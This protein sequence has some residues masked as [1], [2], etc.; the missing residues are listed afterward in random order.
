M[1]GMN[2]S[3]SYILMWLVLAALLGHVI[4]KGGGSGG[5]GA[6]GGTGGFSSGGKKA[7]YSKT[8]TS[9]YSNNKPYSRWD[10]KNGRKTTGESSLVST[11]LGKT[12]STVPRMYKGTRFTQRPI[13][14]VAAAAGVG[15]AGYTAYRFYKN[16][17]V[18]CS[19]KGKSFEFGVG[20]RKCS[21]WMCPIGQ[22][23][24]ACS[25]YSDSYCLPCTNTPFK[26][27]SKESFCE[28]EAASECAGES[29]NTPEVTEG[30]YKQLVAW[31]DWLKA[32]RQKDVP[33]ARTACNGVWSSTECSSK[34]CCYWSPNDVG[35]KCRSRAGDD[36]VCRRLED[37]DVLPR[38]CAGS[39]TNLRNVSH[40]A[41]CKKALKIPCSGVVASGGYVYTSPGNNNDCE[42]KKCSE[43]PAL[44][45][46]ST[47][48]TLAK[49]L[50][51]AEMPVSKAAFTAEISG[52][53]K[54]AIQKVVGPGKEVEVGEVEEL[55]EDTFVF[56][57]RT[58]LP[59]SSWLISGESSS[60]GD[61]AIRGEASAGLDQFSGDQGQRRQQGVTTQ[62]ECAKR[63]CEG[64][65]PVVAIETMVSTPIADIDDTWDMLN[66]KA[67]NTALYN[68]AIPPAVIKFA[69]VENSGSAD[70][71][72][73]DLVTILQTYVL[74]AVLVPL[75][76]L[77]YC[78]FKKKQA[79]GLQQNANSNKAWNEMHPEERNFWVDLGWDEARWSGDCAE[80]TS[81]AKDW[82]ELSEVE[83]AAAT[84]LG[85]NQ[86]IWDTDGSPP[87][88][89][90]SPA[91][92]QVGGAQVAFDK[93][94]QHGPAERNK[95]CPQCGTQ[96]RE[97]GRFCQNCGLA[98]Q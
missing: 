52:R 85:Y 66:D 98:A 93:R 71:V 75:S 42:V 84:A 37:G 12:M 26:K 72:D 11:N 31:K 77:W 81:S 22:Y 2:M 86:E 67:I 18:D 35:Y 74:P 3:R 1:S 65:G 87:P 80:P 14:Y 23:R 38:E 4:C 56:R 70:T 61:N 51:F 78:W 47:D 54:A 97:G 29:A 46:K 44:C 83:K 68:D 9:R 64:T 6:G 15:A 89:V 94:V 63:K 39:L 53:Y 92:P 16:H 21:E 41:A 73:F 7:A 13:V 45:A 58:L 49:I 82:S 10:S 55:P 57:R 88:F 25:R 91:P 43:N 28:N 8:T 90:P 5:G 30:C 34:G 32:E 48:K 59:L 24:A 96:V 20:C 40:S 17:P 69:P 19:T 27:F 95:F 36:Q 60:E 79:R 50:F 33:T 76:V 62:A